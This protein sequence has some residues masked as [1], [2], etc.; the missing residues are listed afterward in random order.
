VD[1]TI[2]RAVV[3]DADS[4]S[5]LY[6][7]ARRAG[8]ETGTIP[9][10]AHSDDEVAGWIKHV[11]I[12][13]LECWLAQTPGGRVVGI[14][15]LRGD[16]IDQ[17][18]VDPDLNRRGI[19]VRLLDLAKRERPHGLRL[20]TFASNDGA[21]RFYERHGFSEVERTN[22]S[23]NEERAPDIQYVWERS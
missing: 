8:A 17:L 14:L 9:L 6:L 12:P 23:R 10:P 16:W 13:K 22:G 21:R 1:L 3:A 18:Y 5:D 19:G 2:R 7:H 15:V 4:A 20:W 11:V